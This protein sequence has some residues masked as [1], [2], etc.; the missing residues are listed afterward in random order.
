MEPDQR[1]ADVAD[2]WRRLKDDGD[3]EARDELVVHYSGLVKFVVGRLRASLPSSVDGHDLT[4]DGVLGLI[5]AIDKYDPGRGLQFQTYAVARIR[6]AVVDGLRAQDWVPRSVREK[7][8]DVN[9]AQAALEKR[10]GRAP[11][12]EEVAAE[13]GVPLAVLH[14]I[15]VETSYTNVVSLDAATSGQSP[16]SLPLADPGQAPEDLPPH[17]LRAVRELPERD[18]IVVALYYWERLTLAEIGQ[19]LGVTE[20]RVSQLHSRATM[21]LR[22]KLAE[23]LDV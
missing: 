18:Q 6:G 10:L 15:Y 16:D 13:L 12:D 22:R 20:S 3:R 11:E 7:I 19:V 1:G 8:R 5:D 14:T 2:L 4:S 23:L 17:F 21:T 9:A